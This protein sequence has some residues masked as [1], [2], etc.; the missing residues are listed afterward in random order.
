M[1]AKRWHCMCACITLPRF[2][3]CSKLVIPQVSHSTKELR[4]PQGYSGIMAK[5]DC[6]LANPNAREHILTARSTAYACKSL[7]VVLC[8]NHDYVMKNI[9]IIVITFFYLS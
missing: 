2:G 6:L 9:I 4:V 8:D 1:A 3:V 7:Q 5:Q